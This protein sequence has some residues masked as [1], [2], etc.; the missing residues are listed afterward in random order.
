MPG[1][2]YSSESKIKPFCGCKVKH[3]NVRQKIV[4]GKY[5]NNVT[6]RNERFQKIVALCRAIGCVAEFEHNPHDVLVAKPSLALLTLI[7]HEILQFE[8]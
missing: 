1:R 8:M 2:I 4:N 3:E 7:K 6:N 5:N